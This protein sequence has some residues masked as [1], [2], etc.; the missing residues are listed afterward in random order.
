MFGLKAFYL[1]HQLRGQENIVFIFSSAG[2][3]LLKIIYISAN[4]ILIIVLHR[5]HPLTHKWKK[6]FFFFI[7]LKMTV[8]I[9]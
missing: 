5:K 2:K 1:L 7:S 9:I 4:I 3:I 8:L 6:I